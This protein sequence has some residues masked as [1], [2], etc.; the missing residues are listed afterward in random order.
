MKTT[1]LAGLGLAAVLSCAGAL[2]FA[3][4]TPANADTADLTFS[5]DTA[6]VTPGS[7]VDVS[8]TL[9][10][11]QSTGIRFV[12]QSIRP[13]WETSRQPDLK[14]AVVS[15]RTEDAPCGFDGAGNLGRAYSLPLA[16]GESRTVTLTYRIAVDSACGRSLG[17]SSYLYYEYGGGLFATSDTSDTYWSP[18]VRVD[19]PPAHS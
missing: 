7:T 1:R 14:Y 4:G 12:Y 16:P 15:C 10:N 8:M 19:C 3:V 13:T 9:T 2:L 5:T 6:A 18:V 17:F 11:T